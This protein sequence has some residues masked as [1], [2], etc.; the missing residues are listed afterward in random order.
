[1]QEKFLIFYN[2]LSDSPFISFFVLFFS[3]YILLTISNYFKIRYEWSTE[4]QSFDERIFLKGVNP[5]IFKILHMIVFFLFQFQVTL[6][7]FMLITG[8]YRLIF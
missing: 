7:L 5:Y 8:I 3:S 6:S 4:I 1:M 2:F